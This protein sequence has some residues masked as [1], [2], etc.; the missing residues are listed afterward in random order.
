[1]QKAIQQLMIGPLCK[2]YDDALKLLRSLKELGFDAIELNRYMIHPTPFF[3]RMLTSLAGMPSGNGGK[4]DWQKL[5]VESGLEVAS[6]HTDLGSLE[7]ETDQIISEAQSFH[8]KYLVITG[9]YRFDYSSISALDELANRLNT[10]G[11][12][13]QKAGISLLYHNHNVEFNRLDNGMLAYEYLV[14]HLDERYVNFELDTY[15]ASEAGINIYQLAQRLGTRLKLHHIN[16]R[17]FKEKGPYMTPIVTSDSME[18]GTGCLDLKLLLEIDRHSQV[19]YVVLETHK[20][21]LNH[22][23]MDSIRKSIEYLNQNI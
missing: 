14:D 16:D 2:K 22:S 23:R 12:K 1:M 6:L 20:N 8:A 17:G 15:W 7:R 11:E 9:M 13:T 4:L 10:V 18:L 21:F 19:E 5:I 3:V